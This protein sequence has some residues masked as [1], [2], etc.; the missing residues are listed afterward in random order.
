LPSLPP[1]PIQ[2]RDFADWQRRQLEIGAYETQLAYWDKKLAG[3]AEPSQLLADHTT[4]SHDTFRGQ[5]LQSVLDEATYDRL[6]AACQREN[7]T[8][9]TWLLAVFQVFL[10]RYTGQQDVCV[11]TGFAARRPRDLE[12]MLGMVLNTV[13]IRSDFGG[14][15][16]F[17][18]MLH[19]LRTTV[20]EAADNQDA[21][22]GHVIE[23]L[24]PNRPGGDAKLFNTFFDSYDLPFPE[25]AEDLQVTAH[26]GLNNGSAKFD[27]VALVIPR[28]NTAADTPG[29]RVVVES[30]TIIWEYATDRF[31]HS[32]AVRMLQHFR[33]LLEASLAHP[34][35]PLTKLGMA[36]SEEQQRI[37]EF[38]RPVASRR[39]TE[40]TVVDLFERHA[41]KR[42][43]AI[44]IDCGDQCMTY[45]ELNARANQLAAHL[46]TLGVRQETMVGICAGRG[47]PLFVGLLGILKAG[48]AYVPLDPDYPPERLAQI[49]RETNAPVLLTEKHLVDR[50]PTA[51][52]TT[53]CLDRDEHMFAVHPSD[54]PVRDIRPESLAYVI[55][56]SGSTGEPKGTKIP[57]SGIVRLVNQPEYVEL[58][59][60][61]VLLQ[62][63]PISFDASTFEIWGALANGARLAVFPE[64]VPALAELAEFVQRL[65]V[66]TMWSTAALF[67]QM[68]EHHLEA[69]TGVRQLLAG[70]DVLSVPHVQRMLDALPAGHRLI[71][72]Y[73]PTENTTFT[74]CHLMDAT[75]QIGRSVPIGRPIAG[76]L[77]YILDVQLQPVP[78]GVPGE[79]YIGGEGLAIEYLNRPQLTADRFI[80]NPF[81]GD[82]DSRLYKSGD[83]CRWLEDGAI[84]F[85]GRRDRQV[86]I[87][88]FRVE[89]GEIE[90]VLSRHPAVRE[91]VAV[92]R[93]DRAGDER[94]I[95][96]V[97][98]HGNSDISGSDLLKFVANRLPSYMHPQAIISVDSIPLAASGKPDHAKLPAYEPDHSLKSF[99]RPP[100]T[101]DERRIC[102]IWR[103]VLNQQNVGVDDNFFHLGGHS[104][105]A[106]QVVSRLRDAYGVNIPLRSFFQSPTIAGLV[107]LVLAARLQARIAAPGDEG[108]VALAHEEGEL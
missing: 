98:Q 75:S 64:H 58:G 84:E 77:V 85:L 38:G 79:L 100:A 81:A 103:R 56:T 49:L 105:L 33:N 26:H 40:L 94:L 7:V 53:I 1:P 70:G 99:A 41:A 9:Y 19:R 14:A 55:F 66:T 50:L 69:L 63:A 102:D 2:D 83:Q 62:F 97:V 60:Q 91:A 93:K 47:M 31:T 86:K 51:R 21:P 52:H 76:T 37:A 44:A 45:G 89:L 82:P 23:R 36:S 4:T 29:G 80:G 5:Q 104:L 74:C 15:P 78:I 59:P 108:P 68:V 48:G 72:G 54:T 90:A 8:T 57:H 73:G 11:G 17:R 88:G 61:E 87:R 25:F 67:H 42:P 3:L 101:A 20:H 27:L 106:M 34:E 16:T 65:R 28:S 6:R 18:D 92:L 43:E 12:S 30:A 107:E 13:A 95:A 71:N 35:A 24:N 32:T 46:Q 96:Y 22:F 10:H 39:I